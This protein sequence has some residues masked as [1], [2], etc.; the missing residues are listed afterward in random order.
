MLSKLSAFQHICK[1]LNTLI[2]RKIKEQS[3]P[4]LTR[5][6]E[7]YNL[8]PTDLT[9][10]KLN[11]VSYGTTLSAHDCFELGRQHYNSGDYD[12]AILWMKEANKRLKEEPE[13]PTV[14]RGDIIEYIAFSY[15]T[16]GNLAKALQY[17]NE[18]IAVEP[19]H[20]RA[21]GNKF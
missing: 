15:Y 14:S 9:H 4:A 2:I 3:F 21:E 1:H 5:L 19:D 18:L 16:Q 12:H 7:T 20:P 17:T 11:G 8:N 6:Q 13:A 10:G